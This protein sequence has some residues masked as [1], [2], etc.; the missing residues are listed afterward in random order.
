MKFIFIFILYFNLNVNPKI[1]IIFEI[2]IHLETQELPRSF[3]S[4]EGRIG[5]RGPMIEIGFIGLLI[6]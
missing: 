2:K 4:S 1:K 5:K 6:Y 3:L